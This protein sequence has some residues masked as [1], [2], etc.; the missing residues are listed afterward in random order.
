LA[1]PFWGGFFIGV[2]YSFLDFLFKFLKHTLFVI[3]LF[4]LGGVIYNFTLPM[5]WTVIVLG[6]GIQALSSLTLAEYYLREFKKRYGEKV[7]N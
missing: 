7:I 1:A 4:F 5:I 2:D 6:M 3:H